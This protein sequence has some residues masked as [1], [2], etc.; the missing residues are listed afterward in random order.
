MVNNKL[1]INMVIDIQNQNYFSRKW[2]MIM[3]A[4]I[5]Y[6]FSPKQVGQIF[7]LLLIGPIF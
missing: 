3:R 4:T 7:I 5:I 6:L 1:Y 2:Y